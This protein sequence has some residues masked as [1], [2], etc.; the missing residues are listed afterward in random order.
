MNNRM[1][2]DNFIIFAMKHYDNPNCHGVDEFQ[3]DLNRM[4]YVKRLL[5]R[6]RRNG[7]L[8]ERL[9]LNHIIIFCN[10]FGNEMGVKMMFFKLH[11]DLHPALKTFFTFLNIM[12]ESIYGISE[13]PILNSDLPIDFKIANALRRI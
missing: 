4:K 10:M 7:D 6:Y 2:E 8:K 11:K 3:E 12:P 5:N 1:T 13:K 9:I